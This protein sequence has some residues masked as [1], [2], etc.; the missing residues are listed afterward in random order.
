MQRSSDK[1]IK[2]EREY[3]SDKDL[4]AGETAT[5]QVAESDENLDTVPHANERI[6]KHQLSVTEETAKPKESSDAEEAR[7]A[8]N[9]EKV[10]IQT[11]DWYVFMLTLILVIG[12]AM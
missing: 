3:K 1:N 10:T 9:A 11:Q 4:Y 7:V 12:V 5:S 8:M 2:E 6:G